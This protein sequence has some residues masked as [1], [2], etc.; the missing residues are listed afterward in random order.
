MNDSFIVVLTLANIGWDAKRRSP[1]E[2]DA[3]KASLCKIT[4]AT[5]MKSIMIFLAK[6][7]PIFETRTLIYVN[8]VRVFSPQ[9]TPKNA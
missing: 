2:S 3:S 8:S 1:N 7:F 6:K 4:H 5:S 9:L